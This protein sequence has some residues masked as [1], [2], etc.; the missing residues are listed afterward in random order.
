MRWEYRDPALI[1][2]FVPA[3]LAHVT[4]EYFGGFPEWFAHIS[5]S[6]LPRA[7]FLLINAVALVLITASVY[8]AARRE[9]MGWLAIGIATILLVNGVGHAL[10]SIVTG[11]YSPGLIT[12]VVLYFPL[13]QLAL[14]RAW[15]QAP[16]AI[17]MRGIL[18]G[19][20][21]HAAVTLIAL[22]SV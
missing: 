13:G 1:W 6:P 11:T 4:E 10:G 7:D 2:L 14:L 16:R 8:V 20:A 9:S 18:A 3:Y 22:A 12:G 5:G 17:L 15:D 19:L 21:A